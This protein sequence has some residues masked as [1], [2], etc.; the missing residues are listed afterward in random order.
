ML[1]KRRSTNGFPVAASSTSWRIPSSILTRTTMA[2][3]NTMGSPMD[4]IGFLMGS[5][6]GFPAPISILSGRGVRVRPSPHVG[7][8]Y[9]MFRVAGRGSARFELNEMMELKYITSCRC[10]TQPIH[11]PSTES[12]RIWSDQKWKVTRETKRPGSHPMALPSPRPI[13][14]YRC[15]PWVYYRYP[16]HQIL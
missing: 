13:L 2:W 10:S 6:N 8:W 15:H 5:S 12:T 7:T 9:T 16:Y 11:R 3:R 1:K 4:A 14:P